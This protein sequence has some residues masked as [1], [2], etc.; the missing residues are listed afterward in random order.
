MP[1]YDP[2]EL[3]LPKRQGYLTS[4]VGPRPIAFASTID[5]DG[6]VNLAPYSFFNA[7]S[8]EPPVLVFSSNRSGRTGETKDT[9][10]NIKE[11]MEVCINVVTYDMVQQVSFASSEFPRGVNE[12]EKAG[13]TPIASETIKPPRVKESPVQFECKVKQVIELGDQGGAGNLFIC[14]I[15][16]MHIA[17]EVIAENGRIDQA[18]LDLVGR[19]GGNWYVRVNESSLFEVPK[20]KK[21]LG[22]GIDQFP[23]GVKRSTVLT[24]NDLGLLASIEKLPGKESVKEVED[25]PEM[26]DI[27]MSDVSLREKLSQKQAQKYLEA[28]EIEKAWKIIL[29]SLGS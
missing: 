27:K 3:P 25:W 10:K 18:K 5:N 24:G 15:L 8:A 23:E 20:P 12:F 1:S 29:W 14:E 17:D 21:P 2:R 6:N 26:A 9:Y 16:R 7:F 11:H 4:A 13:F 19:S 22:I 28:G